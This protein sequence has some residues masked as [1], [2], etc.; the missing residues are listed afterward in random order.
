VEVAPQ[1]E[2]DSLFTAHGGQAVAGENEVGMRSAETVVA[3]VPNVD[4]PAAFIPQGGDEGGLA[5]AA[6]AA[7]AVSMHSV[8]LE[9]PVSAGYDLVL[10]DR[11]DIR[12]AAEVLQDGLDIEAETVAGQVD[13]PGLRPG[14]GEEFLEPRPED[15][16]LQGQGEQPVE[17]RRQKN[18][19][20]L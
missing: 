6:H 18:G 15:G 20:F 16:L 3:P 12:P 5:I 17:V 2:G 8:N 1:G 10:I 13:R 9:R 4:N 14:K 7:A 11:P 19:G